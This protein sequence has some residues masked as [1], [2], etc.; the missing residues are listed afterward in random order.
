MAAQE[1]VLVVVQEVEGDGL[2]FP[3]LSK[4]FKEHQ[5]PDQ[6]QT[7]HELVVVVVVVVLT[8]PFPKKGRAV[9]AAVEAVVTLATLVDVVVLAARVAPQR[10]LR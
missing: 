3:T 6:V 9:E 5:H 7:H 1:G 4:Q 8:V 10:L 2:V